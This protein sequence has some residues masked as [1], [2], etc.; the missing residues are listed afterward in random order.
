MVLVARA[1]VALLLVAAG[2]WW[3]AAGVDGDDG[4]R[5]WVTASRDVTTMR[6]RRSAAANQRCPSGS[7]PLPPPAKTQRATCH[8]HKD[9][10]RK[11]T[12]SK[13]ELE[14][15]LSETADLRDS[16]ARIEDECAQARSAL[17]DLREWRANY[18]S[19]S[20]DED[21]WDAPVL[22]WIDQL[23]REKSEKHARLGLN[24]GSKR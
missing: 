10:L 3:L 13:A 9:E 21:F 8:Y 18:L 17:E 11:T 7:S 22:A 15:D 5:A 19:F 16:L 2:G 14:R 1:V 12:T 20:Q 6:T 24:P 4:D 23:A